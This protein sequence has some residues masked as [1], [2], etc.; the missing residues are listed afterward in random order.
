MS[1][2]ARRLSPDAFT[3]DSPRSTRSSP[4]LLMA[5]AVPIARE[6]SSS[7]S[8]TRRVASIDS[9]ASERIWRA[10]TANPLPC[11]PE[12]TASMAAFSASMLD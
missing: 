11:S 2:S 7:A 3:S 1:E 4:A 12:R 9:S 10:T 8:R 5:T 6:T